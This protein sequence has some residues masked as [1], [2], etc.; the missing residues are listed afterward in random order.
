MYNLACDLFGRRKRAHKAE[1]LLQKA[2]DLARESLGPEHPK[3]LYR[4][5]EFG[6]GL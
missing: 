3:T 6:S 2:V 1:A 4:D 5:G